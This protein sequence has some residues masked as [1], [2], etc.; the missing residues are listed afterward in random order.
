MCVLVAASFIDPVP[1]EVSNHDRRDPRS[2]RG[3]NGE[4]WSIS[5][6]HTCRGRAKVCGLGAGERGQM[7]LERESAP[8]CFRS[9]DA[10]AAD[11]RHS[12]VALQFH[13][14]AALAQG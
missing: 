3:G 12:C 10:E 2:M 13:N 5:D 1:G 6:G 11:L 7:M 14:L 4:R 9:V 8:N